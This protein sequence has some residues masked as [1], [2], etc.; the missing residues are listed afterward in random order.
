VTD[1]ARARCRE[2]AEALGYPAAACETLVRFVEAVLR[3]GERVN[4]T[5][6]KT[7]DAALPVLALD[8]M[9]V[10]AAASPRVP[11]TVVDLGSGNGLPGVAAALAWPR[12]RVLLVERRGKKAA[13][14]ARCLEACGIG[15]AEAVACDG[16]ELLARRPA[17]AGAVDVVT[18]RAVATLAAI[19]RE[20]APWLAPGG[21]LL[22]WKPDPVDAAEDAE[23]R[24][25]AAALGLSVLEDHV[26][27]VPGATASRRVV[28][29]ERPAR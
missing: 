1:P 4:L 21:R 13:A 29:Y 9:P 12:A 19:A 27:R 24:T 28:R 17:L 22:H 7:L 3:E 8:A 5:G 2:A 11:R 20:A 26:F 10:V 23:G 14:V 6:A 25:A 18:A 16:R 15:N